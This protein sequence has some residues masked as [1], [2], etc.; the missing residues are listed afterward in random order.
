MNKAY[1]GIDIMPC[2]QGNTARVLG[3]AVRHDER[4]II[5]DFYGSAYGYTSDSDT[6]ISSGDPGRNAPNVSSRNYP[7]ASSGT[8]FRNPSKRSAG[9]ASARTAAGRRNR[10][11]RKRA[12]R[13]RRV[14]AVRVCVLA[15]LL[16]VIFITGGIVSR[17]QNR[18]ATECYKYYDTVTVAYQENILDIVRKYDNRDYYKTQSDYV[19]ELCRINNIEYDGTEY[20]EVAPGTNLIVPYYSADLK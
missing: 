1:A 9:N 8:C 7:G 14:M 10:N 11:K 4:C 19:E 12:A 13:A 2:V 18:Q 6:G 20:P 17:A 3:G 15:A 16:T 5:Y